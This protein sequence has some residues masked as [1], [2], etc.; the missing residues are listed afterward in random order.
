MKLSVI[1]PAFNEGNNIVYTLAEVKDLLI[2]L[3]EVKE[4]EIINKTI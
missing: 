1:I 4:F 3:N 2:S